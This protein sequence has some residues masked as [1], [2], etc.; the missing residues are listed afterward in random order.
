MV[1][2]GTMGMYDTLATP[3]LIPCL[4]LCLKNREKNP[5]AGIVRKGEA[6]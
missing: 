3:R 6:L 5:D 4:R 1:L 2:K